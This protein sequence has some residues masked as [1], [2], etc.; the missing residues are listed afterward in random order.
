[1]AAQKQDAMDDI[2]FANEYELG[3]IERRVKLDGRPASDPIFRALFWLCVVSMGAIGIWLGATANPRYELDSD[4]AIDG[5]HKH[6]LDD[7]KACCDKA[8]SYW[9]SSLM[10]VEMYDAGQWSAEGRRL[11]EGGRRLGDKHKPKPDNVWEGFG[12]HPEIPISLFAAIVICSVAF[13]KLVEKFAKT[14]IFGAYFAEFCFLI[15]LY[16]KTEDWIMLVFA[17]LVAIYVVYFRKTLASVAEMVSAAAHAL[18]AM[19]SLLSFVFAWLLVSAVLA[20][21]IICIASAAGNH[22]SVEETTMDSTD[23]YGNEVSYT[24]CGFEASST[25]NT[26]YAWCYFVWLWMWYGATASLMFF[27]SGCVAQYHFDASQVTATLPCALARMALT[28]NSGT[29]SKVAL[30]FQFVEWLRKKARFSHCLR[31]ADPLFWVAVLLKC[32]VWTCLRLLTKFALIFHVITG[33]ELWA[34]GKRTAKLMLSAGLKA[35][36]MESAA[37]NAFALIG[38][39]LSVAI[40]CACWFWM[41]VAYDK[42]VL[43]GGHDGGGLREL[44]VVLLCLILLAPFFAMTLV[45]VIAMLAGNTVNPMWI[46]WLC[47]LFTG[48][49]ANKFFFQAVTA[50]LT[51]A[52]TMFVCIAIDKATDFTHADEEKLPALYKSMKGEFA[53]V[54]AEPIE[55]GKEEV[56]NPVPANAV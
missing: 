40:A 6:Y 34:S 55:S 31:V 48:A 49:I 41:G 16:A 5:V 44:M 7:A 32:C 22:S 36:I 35:M 12:L 19:P 3:T 43:G 29:V 52:D 38:Y 24:E 14:V 33:D 17:A 56:P 23:A 42:D 8:G 37:M 53:A 11:V 47:A 28:T 46:P 21:I 10:C 4:G 27:V 15:F 39:G 54:V 45:V 26:A 18:L 25:A 50:L 2:S 51:A 20:V 1:M 9:G 13:V 30:I